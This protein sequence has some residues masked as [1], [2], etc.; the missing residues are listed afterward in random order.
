MSQEDYTIDNASGAA[1]RADLNSTLAAVV[2]AN[3]GATQPATMYPY[4]VWADTTANKLKIRNGAN[5]AWYEVGTLDTAN[6]GLMLASFFP[7]INSNVTATDEELNKLDG[8]TAS[9]AE[10]NL[11]TG[12]TALSSVADAY[13]IGSIYMNASN[14]ANP[15]SL[16]GFGTWSSFGAGRVLTGLDSSQSEFNAIGETGG[17]KTAAHTLTTAEMPSHDH[18]SLHGGTASGNRPSGWVGV[19]NSLSPNAFGGG[20]DDDDWATTKTTATGGGG[21]HSHSTLQPYIVVYMWKRTA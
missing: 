4:Q 1:V 19:S 17:A 12:Q 10:L 8:L 20:T 2:S 9:T 15:A 21:S 7:N 13:P 3:S 16:L 11:L 14:S 18:T 5:N 6:L